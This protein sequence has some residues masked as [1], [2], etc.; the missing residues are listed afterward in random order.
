MKTNNIYI[1][2][3]ANRE[4]VTA[5]EA[6]MKALKIKFEVRKESP[7]DPGFVEKILQGD[8]DFEAGKGRKVT[9]DELN[10]LWK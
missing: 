9:L 10:K 1:A 8:A 2:Q 6:F 5:L 4:Q 7:Y 3:P